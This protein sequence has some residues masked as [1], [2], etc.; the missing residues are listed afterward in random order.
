MSQLVQTRFFRDVR[1]VIDVLHRIDYVFTKMRAENQLKSVDIVTIVNFIDEKVWRITVKMSIDRNQWKPIGNNDTN[2][3]KILFKEKQ[4]STMMIDFI[5]VQIVN[6]NLREK[7]VWQ[8]IRKIVEQN[9][10]N[11]R[12]R[13]KNVEIGCFHWHLRV[14]VVIR[15]ISPMKKYVFAIGRHDWMKVGTS[16]I[17]SSFRFI[18]HSS[19]C[20]TVSTQTNRCSR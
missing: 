16:K 18:F 9:R 13:K 6:E 3:F 17:T 19:W 2:N 11:K 12:E 14:S 8:N 1:C 5:R 7:S 10:K 15:P 4:R 20:K